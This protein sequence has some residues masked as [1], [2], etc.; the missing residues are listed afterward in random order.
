MKDKKLEEQFNEYFDGAEIPENLAAD[1]KKYVKKPVRTPN[2]IKYFSVAASFLLCCVV[3]IML[4]LY[5]SEAVSPDNA[6]GPY[7]GDTDAPASPSETDQATGQHYYSADELTVSTVSAYSV[8]KLKPELRFIERLALSNKAEVAAYTAEFYGGQTA[9]IK[10]EITYV[11][12]VRDETEIFIEYA[13]GVYEPLKDYNYGERFYYN[14]L[15]FYL[16]SE[17][18][19]NGEPVSKVYT[20]K[21][22][23]KYYFNVTSSDKDSYKKYL[24][25]ILG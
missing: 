19:E 21:D 6:E 12:G 11:D 5:N 22:G 9:F 20:V 8:S 23:V 13:S 4:I 7:Y 17:I 15:T 16:T 24:Q 14:G 18:A 25:L 1:A 10:A 3:A 2:F